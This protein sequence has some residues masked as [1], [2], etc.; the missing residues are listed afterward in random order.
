MDTHR[1]SRDTR[2]SRARSNGVRSRMVMRLVLLLALAAATLALTQCQMVGDNLTGV[3]ASEFKR[4]NECARKCADQQ[5]DAEKAERKL[6]KDNEKACSGNS[7][8][9]KQ[10][11]ERHEAA[12]DAI[13]AAYRTCVN[14]C[15]NQGGGHGDDDD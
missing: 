2:E 7:A 6:H 8:C 12:E 15:H 14:G 9:L 3:R 4:K 5:K 13:E 11:K 10:E 1:S